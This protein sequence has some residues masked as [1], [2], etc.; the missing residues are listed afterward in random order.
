[1]KKLLVLTAALVLSFTSYSQQT[2]KGVFDHAIYARLAYGMPGS[3]LKT[4][5]VI[6]MSGLFEAG[7]I[8]Y[9][10]AL[11]LPG[12]LKL[13]IDVT[14]VSATSL[15]NRQ[16]ATDNNETVSYFT[17]GAK[18][19]PCLSWNFAGKCI[20][21]VYY[22]AHPNYFITGQK[23]D[24]YTAENQFKFGTSFGLNLRWNALMLGCEFT[25]ASY[26][27]SKITAN[28]QV[29]AGAETEAMKIPVTNLSLGV[30]F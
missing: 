22:K 18:L 29:I 1:M 16:D 6:D 10:H 3:P 30:K 13:G 17:A 23:D 24:V 7:T 19:G 20:A 8:F 28:K 27:F 25:S 12:T 2:D 15:F 14:Y 5:G 9:I 26:D 4:D 11:K 21:D